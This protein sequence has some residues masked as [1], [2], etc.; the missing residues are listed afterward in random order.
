MQH[1]AKYASLNIAEI[2]PNKSVIVYYDVTR[3][4]SRRKKPF[5]T[6]IDRVDLEYIK[7][8]IDHLGITLR[9]IALID[10]KIQ[11]IEK[12]VIR[13]YIKDL[14]KVW[15]GL[16]I[17]DSPCAVLRANGNLPESKFSR[18]KLKYFGQLHFD[19]NIFPDDNPKQIFY[20]NASHIGILSLKQKVC[21][22]FMEYFRGSVVAY[23]HD[24]I[25]LTHGNLS[26]RTA[27]NKLKCYVNNALEYNYKIIFNS[28]FSRNTFS[29]YF[30]L[31]N[32][33]K[34][35]EIQYPI[36]N[37][38]SNAEV[39]PF[40]KDLLN[41][42]FSLIVGT[43]EPRKNHYF[44]LNLLVEL[45]RKKID[46]DIQK[47]VIVGKRGW[48]N[49]KTFNLLDHLKVKNDYIMEIND[50]NDAEVS[51][52]MKNTSLALFPSIVEGFNM[53]FYFAVSSGILTIASDIELH[54]EVID[55]CR[56]CNNVHLTSLEINKWMNVF[57]D[58]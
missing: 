37:R 58:L 27:K 36:L 28:E 6:G 21:K 7:Q 24:L 38:V 42:E 8:H 50:A 20:F 52:L 34:D 47:F 12:D 31:E 22:S 4:I 9:C 15:T 26:T 23:I 44:L 18:I 39:R 49:K 40:I 54:K 10:D 33:I 32:C 25:P 48:K 46:S 57:K 19:E 2:Y 43:I 30:S 35:F 14:A 55:I 3:L 17:E 11:L 56:P 1:L 16:K 5:A 45:V 41:S 53:D 13:K 29:K 51:F